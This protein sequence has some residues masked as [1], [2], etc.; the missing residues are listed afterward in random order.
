MKN[1][2]LKTTPFAGEIVF[3]KTARDHARRK[4]KNL[5]GYPATGAHLYV[6]PQSKEFT[7]PNPSHHI[8]M[9]TSRPIGLCLSMIATTA[10][11]AFNSS[12]QT[13]AGIHSPA[14]VNPS[15]T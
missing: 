15:A 11:S 5:P 13:S 9:K 1:H 14:E 12:A 3:T 6:Q 7:M 10:L 4:D 8:I 2:Q